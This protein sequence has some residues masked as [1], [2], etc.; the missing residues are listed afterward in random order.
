LPKCASTRAQRLFQY[1]AMLGFG[2]PPVFGSPALERFNDILGN[3]SNQ[4]LRHNRP[5]DALNDIA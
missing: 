5:D 4:E 3:I 1:D 2:A